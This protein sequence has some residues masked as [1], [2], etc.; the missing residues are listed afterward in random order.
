[1]EEI[2]IKNGSDNKNYNKTSPFANFFGDAFND[3]LLIRN[4]KNSPAALRLPA[5]MWFVIAG[6]DEA[7]PR[8]FRINQPAFIAAG[9]GKAD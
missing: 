7:L 2:L 3:K 5:D 6:E 4:D 8:V 9:A 1:M